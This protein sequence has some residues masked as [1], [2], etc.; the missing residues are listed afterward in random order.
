LSAWGD[1]QV[2]LRHTD[3]PV[4]PLC[5]EKA[6]QAHPEL[7]AWYGR[8]KSRYPNVHISW[9]YRGAEDQEKAVLEG[10]SK[11]HYPKSQHNKTDAQGKPQAHALDL[12]LIDEDGAARF[13]P[14]FYAK[15]NAENEANREAILW[16]GRWKK[17]GDLDHFEMQG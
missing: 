1:G 10:K 7:A 2:R 16:G 12:F 17:F 14:M 5:T 4:C 8:V 15:L 6:L 13:P 3:D 9:S 11:L